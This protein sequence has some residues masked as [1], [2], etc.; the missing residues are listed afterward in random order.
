MSGANE[1]TSQ[2]GRL[3]KLQTVLG[4]DTLVPTKISGSEGLSSLFSYTLEVFSDT[5]HDIKANELVGTQATFSLFQSDKTYRHFNGFIESLV[6]THVQRGGQQ[7]CY[8]ITIISWLG[9]LANSS[10]CRIFQDK[11]VPDI[12]T[13]V[14]N[15]HA[16]SK[17]DK[18]LQ[19]HHPKH[20]YTVQYHET[21]LAFVQR[22]MRREGIAFY[23]THK[24]GEHTL[25]LVDKGHTLPALSPSDKLYLHSGDRLH[26]Q[27]TSWENTNQFVTGKYKQK[28]YNYKTPS[29]KLKLKAN[30]EGETSTIPQ[31]M[32]MEHYR[33]NV[34]YGTSGDGNPDTEQRR[35]DGVERQ[36]IVYGAGHCRHLQAG[37]TFTV[38]TI[39]ANAE[40]PDSGKPFTLTQVNWTASDHT[41]TSQAT[42]SDMV[43]YSMQF[44]AISKGGLIAPAAQVTPRINGMQTAVV[45]GPPG[46]EIHTDK[47]GRICVKFHWDERPDTE[48]NGETSCWMRVMQSMA[49]PGFG[50]QFTP[51]IGQEVVIAFEEG[52]PDRPFVIGVLYHGEHAPPYDSHNGTRNGIK[53]RSTKGGGASNYNELYF[54]DKKGKEQVYLHAEKDFDLKIENNQSHVIDHNLSYKVGDNE[55]HMVG[56]E[57]VIDAG[58]KILLKVGGSTITI[59]SSS[60]DIKSPTVNI[61]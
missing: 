36:Q 37:H 6:S 2:K 9:M 20:A 12:I 24:Q 4:G 10:N 35:N 33:Y 43:G 31:V 61:N 47:L 3:I 14:F 45:N 54:E 16:I 23:F 30:A 29:T 40:W 56:K 49:G 42:T 52:H 5:R 19:G 59:T 32:G 44:E 48:R 41:H 11:T 60:I 7:S 58:S 50:A 38:D 17:F 57:V 39:P 28:A 27:L 18:K 22:L 51:R 26:D 21:D 53:T 25:H 1:P 34:D 8:R 46:S 55:T 15:L 13:E